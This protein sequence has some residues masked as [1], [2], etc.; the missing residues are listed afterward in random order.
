MGPVI[1]LIAGSYEQIAFGYRVSTG[2]EEWTA[3][4]DFTHHA[5]TASV[6]AVATSE[7]YIATG[8][9]DETIQIYDMKKRVEHGALLHHDGTISCL[10]F[11]GSS[12]LLSGGQDGLLCVWSTRNWECLKSIRAH[13]GQVTSLSVHPSGKLA[14][15][16]GTDKTLR[17]A[18]C[19]EYIFGSC[20]RCSKHS[21]GTKL[22]DGFCGCRT[23]NLI[24]GRSA[25]IKNI[26]Q[27]AVIVKWSPEGD[28]YVV[29]IGDKVDVYDLET[30]TLTSTIINPKRISSIKF[31]TN[32]ILAIAGD[33]ET[34][35]LCDI[36]TQ[37]V[38][39][40][41]E[42]HETR[43]KSVDSFTVDDFCVLVT[44]SNDGFI[45]MWKLNLESLEP[46]VLLGKVNTTARLTCLAVWKPT[47]LQEPPPEVKTEPTTSHDVKDVLELE[48]KRKRKRVR[49]STVEVVQ[50]EDASPKKKKDGG[51]KK[52]KT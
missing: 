19:F 45:K 9:R 20:C 26:K 25:F 48:K 31:L 12:H 15:T 23:W 32:S 49:I 38:L 4:A 36:N 35:R 37:K 44:A 16:V 46:P 8:S 40:E 47:T 1:E 21:L 41:F 50:E 5:H 6:S 11:Y 2:E 29:V 30:A 17:F 22:T 34:V 10:E 13:K 39:C 28:K 18:F 7:R 52:L 33:D 3:T 51:K 42:A 24:D 43:V 14:L 27:N